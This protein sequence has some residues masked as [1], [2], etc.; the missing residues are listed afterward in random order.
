MKSSTVPVEP[1]PPRPAETL[2]DEQLA[3]YR[4]TGYLQLDSFVSI[5][6]LDELRAASAEFVERSRTLTASDR[7][8]DVEPDHTAEAPRLRRLVSPLDHHETFFR[9]TIEGPPA[10][11]AMQLLGGPVR[12][13]HSKLNY[14]WS[15]GGRGGQVASR[16]PVL[17]PHG[18]HPSDDRGVPL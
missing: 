16:H 5:E 15:D 14:K 6:W 17:A 4:E 1:R 11:L 3:A 7:V 18:L 13:H 9:F 12:F 8:L 2:T 10:Q